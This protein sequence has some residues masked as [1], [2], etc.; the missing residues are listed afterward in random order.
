MPWAHAPAVRCEGRVQTGTDTINWALNCSE[1][2]NPNRKL[3]LNL[4]PKTLKP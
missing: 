1:T 4:K 2:L 3:L